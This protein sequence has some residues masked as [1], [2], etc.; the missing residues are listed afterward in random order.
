MRGAEVTVTGPT[1]LTRSSGSKPLIHIRHPVYIWQELVQDCR[2]LMVLA[3]AAKFRCQLIPSKPPLG[4][5]SPLRT[6][7]CFTRSNQHV[8]RGGPEIAGNGMRQHMSLGAIQY[9]ICVQVERGPV[10]M[11]DSAIGDSKRQGTTGMALGDSGR[12]K[13][14]SSAIGKDHE[15]VRSPVRPQN[16]SAIAPL[17][18]GR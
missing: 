2:S 1:R 8:G 3:S 6:C 9:N 12:D 4:R 5:A 11:F 15:P 10:Q 13:R 18:V 16:L 17:L 14:K 7:G